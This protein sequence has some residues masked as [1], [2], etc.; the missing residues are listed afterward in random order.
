V[1]GIGSDP[2]FA[3]LQRDVGNGRRSGRSADAAGTAAPEPKVLG[4]AIWGQSPYL[5]FVFDL[6]VH[7]W[8][9]TKA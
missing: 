9:L 8:R 2:L 7:R 3:V 4:A 1:S 6:W 5:H